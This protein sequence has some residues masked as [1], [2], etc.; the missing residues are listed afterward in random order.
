MAGPPISR[1]DIVGGQA[2]AGAECGEPNREWAFQ[3]RASVTLEFPSST[4]YQLHGSKIVGAGLLELYFAQV[5]VSVFVFD[6]R[7]KIERVRPRIDFEYYCITFIV[8]K[9]PTLFNSMVISVLIG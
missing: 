2:L 3:R 9:S 4:K 5:T 6:L 7:S 8:A 1:D